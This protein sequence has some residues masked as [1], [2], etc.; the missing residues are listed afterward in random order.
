MKGG[1][2]RLK[3]PEKCANDGQHLGSRKGGSLDA[4][5]SHGKEYFLDLITYGHMF[6]VGMIKQLNYR[7]LRQIVQLIF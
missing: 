2:W 6:I 7:F 1:E 3:A 5:M 4:P